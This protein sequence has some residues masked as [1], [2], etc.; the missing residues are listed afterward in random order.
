MTEMHISW[1][2]KYSKLPLYSTHEMATD[3]SNISQTQQDSSLL[4]WAF[5][6]SVFQCQ[7]HFCNLTEGSKWK[8]NDELLRA[9]KVLRE[10]P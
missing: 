10:T 3:L 9:F 8:I 5:F 4:T 2:P 7:I 1:A 6:G